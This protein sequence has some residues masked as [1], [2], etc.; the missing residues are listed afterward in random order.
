MT[1]ICLEHAGDA[2]AEWERN[3]IDLIAYGHSEIWYLFKIH[4]CLLTKST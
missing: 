4:E 3:D 2:L 1:F